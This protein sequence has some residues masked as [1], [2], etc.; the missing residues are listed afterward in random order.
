MQLQPGEALF[1]YSIFGLILIPFFKFHKFLN[2]IIGT[3]LLIIVLYLDAKILIPL[4]Y[5]ILGLTTA[6][7]GVI[8]RFNTHKKLWTAIAVISGIISAFGWYL[9]EKVYAEA[10]YE[11]SPLNTETAIN[12]KVEIVNHYNH[13]ITI[14]SPFM[15]LFYVSCLILLLNVSWVRILLCPLKYYGRMALTNYICQTLM[16]YLVIT[17]FSGIKWTYVDTLWICLS[18]YVIQLFMS[19]IWLKYFK[20]GPLEYIWKMATYMRKIKIY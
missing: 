2:L 18:I 16:I 4:P 17:L 19:S 1:I 13:L 10:H 9:L 5:F 15:S 14:F 11:L 20:L 3:I 8:F 7:F 12:N 6:Q